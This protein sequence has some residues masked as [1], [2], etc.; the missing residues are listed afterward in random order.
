M[1]GFAV[2][3]VAGATIAQAEDKNTALQEA[4]K[5]GDMKEVTRLLNE[6]AEINF[7]ATSGDSTNC[8]FGAGA[9]GRC[10]CSVGQ[11]SGCKSQDSEGLD[12]TDVG[13]G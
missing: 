3:W 9:R 11:R 7:T 8:G 6:V 4:S 12:G 10:K 1:I 13:S 5:K 2:L